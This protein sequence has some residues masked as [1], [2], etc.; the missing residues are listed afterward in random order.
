ME[1]YAL[2]EMSGKVTEHLAAKYQNIKEGVKKIMA[3]QI[4]D[5]E[6]KIILNRGIQ[7]GMEQGMEQG[8]QALASY[9]SNNGKSNQEIIEMLKAI[10]GLT[11]KEAEAF[12]PL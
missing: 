6:A 9:Y 4:L 7:Q 3:G 1:K 10:Y 12:L 5:Y 2:I 11:S 8:I